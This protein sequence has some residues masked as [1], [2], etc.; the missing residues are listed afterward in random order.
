MTTIRRRSM[1]RDPNALRGRGD[2]SLS[3]PPRPWREP[4]SSHFAGQHLAPRGGVVPVISFLAQGWV[5]VLA[6]L[7]IG[8]V[9]LA[10]SPRSEPAE[11]VVLKEPAGLVRSLW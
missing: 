11:R 8:G 3:A 4:C 10:G 1:T 5:T 2:R 6:I 9:Y 7:V